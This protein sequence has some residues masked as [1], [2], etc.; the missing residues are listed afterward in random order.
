MLPLLNKTITKNANTI[1]ESYVTGYWSAMSLKSNLRCGEVRVHFLY[2]DH[3]WPRDALQEYAIL[4]LFEEEFI[5]LNLTTALQIWQC[6]MNFKTRTE[7]DIVPIKQ[8]FICQFLLNINGFCEKLQERKKLNS[9]YNEEN[10]TILNK[11]ILDLTEEALLKGILK[12]N[13]SPFKSRT[14]RKKVRFALE[15]V[16]SSLKRCAAV[17]DLRLVGVALPWWK[18]VVSFVLHGGHRC[19][20][21]DS[22]STKHSLFSKPSL[23][24][25]RISLSRNGRGDASS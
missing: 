3:C 24:K 21:P 19:H 13:E 18:R 5:A 11:N 12:T 4:A 17:S 6:N 9:R 16:E 25:W 23:A 20:E 2:F 7:S 14:S 1:K 22:L 8:N 15:P 10:Y